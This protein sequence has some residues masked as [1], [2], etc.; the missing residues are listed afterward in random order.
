MKLSKI[1]MINCAVPIRRLSS[2]YTREVKLKKEPIQVLID[3][4]CIKSIVHPLCVERGGGGGC[5]T[6]TSHSL[7]SSQSDFSGGGGE[8]S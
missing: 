2:A 7:P 6:H 1:E 8:K 5:E 3:T 4:G